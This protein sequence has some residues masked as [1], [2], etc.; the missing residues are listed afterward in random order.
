MY[1]F[2]K[3]NFQVS[4]TLPLACKG[5]SQPHETFPENSGVILTDPSTTNIPLITLM[6]F[7]YAFAVT[8]DKQVLFHVL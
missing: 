7:L 4:N 1:T 5:I 8:K 2:V 6:L 3:E